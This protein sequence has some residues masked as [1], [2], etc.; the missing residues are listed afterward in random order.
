[1]LK[2]NLGKIAIRMERD[3]E[4]K[5]WPNCSNC[6]FVFVCF[7]V[8]MPN[9]KIVSAVRPDWDFM[10]AGC[11]PRPLC[12]LGLALGEAGRQGGLNQ[13]LNKHL[14]PGGWRPGKLM[15]TCYRAWGNLFTH[16]RTQ[17]LDYGLSNF[18]SANWGNNGYFMWILCKDS[19]MFIYGL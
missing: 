10:K 11:L 5:P 4:M 7:F 1:M 16:R 6:V 12:R 15:G 19:E 3:M 13:L 14:T 8:K 2:H 18:S 17:N 9:D